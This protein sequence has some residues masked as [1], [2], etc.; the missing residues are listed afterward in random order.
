M[1]RSDIIGRY[2]FFTAGSCG[3]CRFGMYAAE[4]RLA[5]Q[6]AGFDGFR[7]I[8]FQQDHGVRQQSHE[9][10]LTYTLDFG[11]GMLK[12]L[13]LGDLLNDIVCNLR[14]Y[15]IQ[16]GET[17]RV[18]NEIVDD[19]CEHLRTYK[20]PEPMDV[21]PSCL[22]R[23][24]ANRKIPRHMICVPYK[25]RR[26]LRGEAFIEALHRCRDRIGRIKLDRTR[27][28]P[29]VKIVGE[30]WAQTTEGDGN[31]RM[32]EF[33]E[34]EGAQVQ[35]EAI[36]T[37]LTYLMSQARRQLQPRRGLNEQ[38][39]EPRRWG[40]RQ[41]ARIELGYQERRALLWLGEWAYTRLYHRMLEELGAVAHR[42]VPQDRL[43]RLADPFYRTLARGGEGYLEV[44]KNIYYNLNRLCHMVLSLKPFGCMPSSQS[45]GI[46]SAVVNR[47]KDM[48]F[49]PI[50][51]SGEGEVNAHSRVQMALGEAKLKAKS[52]FQRA[53]SA[54]G[55]P[56]EEIR[57]FVEKHPELRSPLYRVPR[58]SGYA[59]LAASF[60]L[61]VNNLMKSKMILR[62]LRPGIIARKTCFSG[63]NRLIPPAAGQYRVGLDVGSTTVKAVVV[64]AQ[65]AEVLWQDYRRHDTRLAEMTLDFL[66]RAEREV[67]I[68]PANAR[69]FITGSG[70]N[71]LA[72]IIGAKPV[73]EV[74]AA[75][76]EVGRV[77]PKAGSM[78]EVGGQDA[79]IVIFKRESADGQVKKIPSMNDKCAGGTGAVIDKISRKLGISERE[80]SR[81]RYS[82]IRL[83]P[84][85]GKCGVFAETD[86]NGL[87]KQGIPPAELMASLFE[88]FVLQNLKVLAR[89]NTLMPH[90]VLLGGANHFIPGMREAWQRN[91]ALM[92]QERGVRVPDARPEEL[93]YAP[94]NAQYYGALGAAEYGKDEEYEVGRYLGTSRLESYLS[95]GRIQSGARGGVPGLVASKKEEQEF[96]RTYAPPIFVPPSFVTG[97]RVR[98]FIGVDAGST[99]TKA[100]LVSKKNEVL[101]KAYQL[102]KGNPIEDTVEIL[103]KLRAQVEGRGASIEVL[104]V[105]T[106][107]YAK[108]T[109]RDVICADVA[110]VETVAHAKSALH[111]YDQPDVICDVGGQDIKL[112]ILKDGRVKD[113]KFNTQCSAGNGYFL[114]AIAHSFGFRVEQ[115]ADAAFSARSIPVFPYGCAIFLQSD[116]LASDGSC[117]SSFCWQGAAIW[118]S[119]IGTRTIAILRIR[120]T[121][122]SMP[123]RAPIFFGWSS[124]STT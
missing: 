113:F 123:R 59:G 88:A 8:R 51:T 107:G 65:T 81:L 120:A 15:E 82:G 118:E 61:H 69:I 47:F 30:F 2:L 33:L 87:Q 63:E 90:V 58:Y 45:D 39:E 112:I 122:S 89:G 121:L 75:C 83:H 17:D 52:E 54:T 56:L 109:L 27:V 99:S 26:H 98:G 6:N 68:S 74:L 1:S 117:F 111:Y 101:V 76:L 34:R 116:S 79:K 92:W 66:H 25:V 18:M 50:E 48:I 93:I 96:L 11:L 44:G 85:A 41:R 102:S 38:G 14:P 12:A 42:L 57:A 22:A 103:E 119:R 108:D 86:I 31:Y 67:G 104:G 29:I 13:F 32:F 62:P 124:A 21:M 71:R 100:V 16:P 110:L 23:L 7:V 43:A 94:D 4:Y 91:I 115:Y 114:Q 105:A 37:W 80:L 95:S 5:L 77:C 70:G 64:N 84:V 19:L 72:P 60:I 46:Q 10:G 73:Q 49:L 55:K 28:K 40:L 9:P 20:P 97:E 78:V 106:T 36:G 53:L 35:P 24:V 3:P